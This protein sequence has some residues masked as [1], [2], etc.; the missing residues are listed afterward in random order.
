MDAPA[1]ALWPLASDTNRFNRDTGLP[2]V[3]DDRDTGEE[4]ENARRKLRITLNGFIPIAWEELPFE[5]VRPWRFGVVR[6]YRGGP[7]KEMR[8]L[9]ELDPIDGERCRIVYSVA[10]TPNGLLGRIIVPVQI[11]ILS[12]RAFEKAFR[13]YAEHVRRTGASTPIPQD[14]PK[15]IQRLSGAVGRLVDAGVRSLVAEKLITHLSS[16]D[17]LSLVRI[18]PALLARLWE[19]P[20]AEMLE[21]CLEATRL[22]ILDLQ[23]DLLCPS[24][25]GSKEDVATLSE[26]R[27]RKAVHCDTC[28]I[29]FS[30]D[31][32]RSVE[33]T[34]HPNASYRRAADALFCV[35]GP[36]VTPQV[37]VQQLVE[38][39]ETRE[40]RPLLN[41]GGYRVRILGGPSG[42]G[43][44][45]DPAAGNATHDVR[46]GLEGISV[47]GEDVTGPESTFRIH[48]DTPV[49]RLVQIERTAW[50]DD[51][52]TAAEVTR[53]QTFRDLFSSEVLEYGEFVSVGSLTLVFTDLR[54]STRLYTRVGDA[55]AYGRVMEHFEVLR[56]AIVNEGGSVVKT[57]GDAVMA[58]FPTPAPALAALDA[59]R[60]ELRLREDGEPLVLKAGLH[61]GPCIA[62][63]LNDRLDYF[64]TTVNVAARLGSLSSGEDTVISDEV[65][66]DPGVE[67]Y[68]ADARADVAS[69]NV[70][71]RGID[72]GARIWRVTTEWGSGR[73]GG[74]RGGGDAPGPGERFGDAPFDISIP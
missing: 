30:V 48:N 44:V 61:H 53:N 10:V 25:S 4:L 37:L 9:C 49:E 40:V 74:A 13:S 58:V 59:A 20:R 22:G 8:V 43:F 26:L 68:L 15:A 34:F 46:I 70:S 66:R 24:C 64:G 31:F 51:V 56:E 19:L 35:A 7:L 65:R 6:R 1:E 33:L 67:A 71:L 5:W 17:A 29:D 47:D 54:D 36:Q 39:G 41:A 28:R 12:R 3:H 69:A 62:V 18:R 14:D 23:W 45:V 21:A 57:I 72:G 32:D 63:T 60:R 50:T 73:G 27:T 55:R 11:G 38:P 2:V 42:G 16:A 52:V